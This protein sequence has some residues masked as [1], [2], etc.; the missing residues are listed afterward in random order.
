MSRSE[1]SRRRTRFAGLR[2]DQQVTIVTRLG[3]TPVLTGDPNRDHY[4]M[5][6]ALNN[7]GR[8]LA[9]DEFLD[10]AETGTPI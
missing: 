10:R 5:T 8:W 3:L 4:L 2:Y 9:V 1:G 7:S 6:Q